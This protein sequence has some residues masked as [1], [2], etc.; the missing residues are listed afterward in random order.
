MKEQTIYVLWDE[1]DGTRMGRF[2][3]DRESATIALSEHYTSYWIQT[4]KAKVNEVEAVSYF[5]ETHK[6][7]N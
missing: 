4:G 3:L 1:Q 5:D 7:I 6:P 2:Y